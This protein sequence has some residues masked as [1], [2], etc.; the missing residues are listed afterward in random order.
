MNL[1]RRSIKA[2]RCSPNDIPASAHSLT[3]AVKHGNCCLPGYAGI[4][5]R[6]AILEPYFAG[7]RNVLASLSDVRFDHDT[8]DEGGSVGRFKLASLKN[9]VTMQTSSEP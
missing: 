7:G 9:E 6:L 5:H 8:H 3:E 2:L 4:G 1:R